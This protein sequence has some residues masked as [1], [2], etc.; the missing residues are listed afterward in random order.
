MVNDTTRLLGLDGLVVVKVEDAMGEQPPVVH[1]ATADEQARCCP[2]C[3]T[4]ARR[5]KAWATTRPRDLPVA[6][7]SVR[8]RWRKRRWYSDNADCD[9]GSF[10]ESVTQVPPRSRL[11]RRLR[12]CA[13]AAVA[14]AGR[15]VVQA[16][17]DHH[18]SWPVVSAAFTTYAEQVLPDQPAPVAA[19]GIDEVRR[20]RPQWVLDETTGT[21]QTA[22]D[23]WHVGFVDLSGGQGLLGQV[24]GRTSAAVLDWLHQRPPAWREQ[25]RFVAIDMCPAF[26]K[27]ARLGRYQ[28]FCVTEVRD[29]KLKPV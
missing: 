9:R 12:A 8:L 14:D 18:V 23:R 21:W 26:A 11:T 13:G 28:G 6:G 20:G 29:K 3:A 17:R 2:Q 24:E 1:L 16:A 27:A 22:V 25:V 4:R 5:V 7:R 10:T 19:L 15:A